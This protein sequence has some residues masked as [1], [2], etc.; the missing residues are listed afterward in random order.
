MYTTI[1]AIAN[2]VLNLVLIPPYG[3]HGSAWATVATELLTMS[4]MMVTVLR[5]MRLR[6]RLG[7]ILRT[8]VLAAAMTGVMTLTAF[9]GLIPASL[10]GGLLYVG[11][12]FAL[13]I[14]NRDE[15]RTLR[16]RGQTEPDPL[17]E[18]PV[19]S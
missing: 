14:V 1:G 6:L 2:V 9:L 10:I 7:K 11:G 17:P 13:R 19:E 12:L 5:A 3:A 15:V 8:V 16:G 4:L 18:P